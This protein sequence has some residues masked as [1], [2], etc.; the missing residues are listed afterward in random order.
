MRVDGLDLRLITELLHNPRLSNTELSDKLAVSE[1][2]VRRRV[3]RLVDSGTIKW[4]VIPDPKK[5]GYNV[6]AFV[7]LEV[8]LGG[9]DKVIQSLSGCKNIDF[10][11]ICTGRV[12]ILLG[13]WFK[14]S[15]EMLDFVKNHLGQIPGIRKSE[16]SVTL[17]VKSFNNAKLA[18][19]EKEAKGPAVPR[20]RA[21]S[22]TTTKKT[23]GRACLAGGQ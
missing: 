21:H 15:D 10:V 5:L 2:T 8:E 18:L 20:V 7:A 6:R 22:S 14:S 19:L 23:P 17:E 3:S 12:D 1:K 9:L 16:T 4:A 11:A 13:A